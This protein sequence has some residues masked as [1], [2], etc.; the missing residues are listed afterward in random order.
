MKE[1]ISLRTANS[2]TYDIGIGKR[3]AVISG[4]I[5][6]Y[7]DNYT[8]KSEQWKDI[9]LTII[10]GKV[11]AAPYELTIDGKKLT[12]RDKK[13]GEISTL[14]LLSVFPPG[15]KFEIKPFNQGVSFQHI[16]PTDKDPFEAQFRIE[17]KALLRTRAFDDAGELE[18]ETSFVDS[19]LTEKL[20]KVKG[21]ETGQTRVVKGDIRIDPTLTV[22]PSAKD[23]QLESE[24]PTTNYGT[25]SRFNIRDYVNKTRRSLL[26]FDI[27]GL[28]SGA[29]INS[30]SLQLY[31]WA[32]EWLADPSGKTVWAY[33]LTRT[34]WVEAQ[35]TWNIYKTGSSWTSSGGD[36][37]TSS[38]AGGST[39]F[40]A[41]FGWMTWNV[42]AI[43]QDAYGS[44][45]AAEFLMKF[46]TEGL[47]ANHSLPNFYS[48]DYTDDTDLCPKLVIVYSVSVA[49]TVTTQAVSSI[50]TTTATGNGNITNN[51]GEDAS[52]WGVCAAETENPDTGDTVFAGSG[53]GGV[54]AFTAPMTGL[55]PGQHYYV[56]AYA[57]NTGGTGYGSQV[58][59]DTLLAGWTGKISGVTNPAKIM[60]V[61]VANIKSVKGVE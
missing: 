26:E 6:H 7:K 12:F 43:V 32:W 56:R 35:A 21:K 29:T 27:S 20:S 58:E 46:A 49:P 17:G 45:I 51:G 39:T 22:Q 47:S 48:N 31:Y 4:N 15:L 24:H 9:D 52:A 36:Y 53:A 16:L 1:L 28:P 59:F 54:G 40:P 23:T 38:P 2:K 30:A 18:L 37:V 55:T 10:D 42:L 41:D 61:A 57:T 25:E 50:G 3:R 13:T 34:D 11:T 8:N 60:G 19:I 33:K 44:S 14:E 5:I